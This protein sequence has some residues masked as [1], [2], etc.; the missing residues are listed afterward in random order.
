M[1]IEQ[2]QTAMIALQD[3]MNDLQ[4]K[5]AE[6][7]KR[8]IEAENEIAACNNYWFSLYSEYS[9]LRKDLEESK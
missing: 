7:H 6:A 4:V 8:K 2:I 3:K 1:K 9:N 5:E